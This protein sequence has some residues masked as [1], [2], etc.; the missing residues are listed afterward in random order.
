MKFNLNKS[1]EIL[2]RTP[3]VLKTLL[4]N[5]SDDWTNNNE[6]GNTWSPKD[7]L[8]HLILGEDTDWIPRTKIFLSKD[9][10][11]KFEPF[12]MVGHLEISRRKSTGELLDEFSRK[13]RDNIKELQELNID[14]EK[15][16]L[17]SIH[18]ELDRVTLKEMLATWVIHD[19]T[20]IAQISRVMAKQ[21]KDEMGP[22]IE[23]FR[24]MT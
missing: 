8:A 23:Y 5:L 4:E 14:E 1:I 16:E 6:G 11:K 17:E 12:D 15:L 20:H 3:D 10:N 13:R 9:K 7:I 22:W 19:L 21:Y 24:V 18:P 2:S